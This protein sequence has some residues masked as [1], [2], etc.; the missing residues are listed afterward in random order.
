[1][2]A[3]HADKTVVK[4]VIDAVN[5]QLE[6]ACYNSEVS[7]VMVGTVDEIAA[8]EAFLA[9]GKFPGIKYQRVE[10]THGFHSRLTEGIIPGLRDMEKSLTYQKP[11]T[12]LQLQ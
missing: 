6:I 5:G 4:T 12:P 9:T 11:H 10:T 7:H 3:I 8:A 1:M 2:L